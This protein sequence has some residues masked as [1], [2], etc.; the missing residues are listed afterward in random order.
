MPA[1]P[2]DPEAEDARNAIKIFVYQKDWIPRLS[3]ANAY[4]LARDV[5]RLDSL[6]LTRVQRATIAR[7]GSARAI[8]GLPQTLRRRDAAPPGPTS[9]L[10]PGSSRDPPTHPDHDHRV[11]NI[12]KLYHVG[13]IYHLQGDGTALAIARD[14]NT[15]AFQEIQVT[16]SM[17]VDHLQP[18]Y[19]QSLAKL[20][21]DSL[22]GSNSKAMRDVV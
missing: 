11:E 20:C 2:S 13:Q 22:S 4:R 19:E 16:A 6:P 21:E 18:F 15:E 12:P 1:S 17:L 7:T 9:P 5:A 14:Y 10:D 3:V 8:H